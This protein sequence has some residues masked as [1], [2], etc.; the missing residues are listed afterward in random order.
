MNL[1]QAQGFVLTAQ[2][3]SFATAAKVLGVYQ[4]NLTVQM[5][6]L[7]DELGVSLFISDKRGT[8]LTDRGRELLPL[9][10]SIVSAYSTILSKCQGRSAVKVG[11]DSIFYQ[12]FTYDYVYRYQKKYPESEIDVVPAGR[13]WELPDKLKNGRI[14]LYF[15]YY[16][17]DLDSIMFHEIFLD[18]VCI[19][20][21]KQLFENKNSVSLKDLEGLNIYYDNEEFYKNRILLDAL[22]KRNINYTGV[23]G[24]AD[25]IIDL[26]VING[27][28]VMIIH[29]AYI[30]TLS[31]QENAIPV[32]GIKVPYGVFYRKNDFSV[33]QFISFLNTSKI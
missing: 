23:P 9:F 3:N 21:G 27:E 10:E 19:A 32:R 14:D 22:N 12:P 28:G 16:R 18:S 31:P 24:Q 33:Q 1:L 26:H 17:D 11:V 25:S 8:Q 30:G 2:N 7:E 13:Y 5:R 29:G 4:Q 15:G 6:K 20:Y